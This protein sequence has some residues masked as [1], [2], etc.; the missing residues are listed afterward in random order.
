MKLK[1][2]WI[3]KTKNAAIQSLTD[4]YLKRIARY[5]QVEGLSLSDETALLRFGV[6]T[7]TRPRQGLI[8]RGVRPISPRPPRP[9]SSAL[10]PG[11]RS[12]RRLHS[13]GKTSSFG[14]HF[15]RSNDPR[16]R[17]RPDRLARTGLPG[18]HD[19]QGSPIP[20]RALTTDLASPCTSVMYPWRGWAIRFGDRRNSPAGQIEDGL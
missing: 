20:H 13:T 6:K 7:G 12:R 8:L 5:T 9:Q 14:D 3:G 15:S 19:S 16:P 4:D 18:I 11:Y 17:T 1:I 2:A 10:S